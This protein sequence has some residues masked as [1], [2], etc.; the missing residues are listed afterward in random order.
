[1]VLFELHQREE[2]LFRLFA[3]GASADRCELLDFLNRLEKNFHANREDLYL[4][5]DRVADQGPPRN[6]E[7][8]HKVDE[9]IWVFVKGSLRVYWFYGDQRR[10]ILCTHS[11]V[12]K[13]QKPKKAIAYA[14]QIRKAYYEE[15]EKGKLEIVPYGDKNEK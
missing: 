8:C 11:I 7:I 12:K 5:L 2:K 3:I 14:K 15:I 13:S 9:D 1:M 6:A 4:L 10:M